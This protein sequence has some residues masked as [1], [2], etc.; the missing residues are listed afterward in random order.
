MRNVQIRN[1]NE[2]D[3]IPYNQTQFPWKSAHISGLS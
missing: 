3:I 2:H 1:D